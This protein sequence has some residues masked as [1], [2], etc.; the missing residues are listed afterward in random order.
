MTT[1]SNPRI[2]YS[3][4]I[5]WSD[6]D[7]AYIVTV[8]ELPGCRTHGA[9]Y[10]EAVEQAQEAIEGWIEAAQADGD[11]VPPPKTF[12][13]CSPLDSTEQTSLKGVAK[14]QTA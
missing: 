13:F 10:E 6:E 5:E 12:T 1:Q 7:D 4:I 14:R 3:M 9:S 11:S 8:P 2:R